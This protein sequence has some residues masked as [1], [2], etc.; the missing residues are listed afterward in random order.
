M[1]EPGM[2]DEGPGWTTTGS[3]GCLHPSQP[4]GFLAPARILQISSVQLG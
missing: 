4:G 3:Q 2:G 1:A